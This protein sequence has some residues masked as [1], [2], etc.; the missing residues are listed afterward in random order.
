ML[1]F[2]PLSKLLFLQLLRLLM[3]LVSSQLP[4]AYKPCFNAC[5]KSKHAV[6]VLAYRR[7]TGSCFAFG[8]PFE[9]PP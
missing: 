8:L 4:R 6:S 7:D 2:Y 9:A 1:R 3:K 5:S